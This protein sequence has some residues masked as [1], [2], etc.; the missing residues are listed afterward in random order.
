MISRVGGENVVKN[1]IKGHFDYKNVR[2]SP[3]PPYVPIRTL[4]FLIQ[5]RKGLNF[6]WTLEKTGG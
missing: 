2:L 1:V 4:V 6:G 3:S 5:E